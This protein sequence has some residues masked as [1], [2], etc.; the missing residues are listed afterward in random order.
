M[1]GYRERKLCDGSTDPSRED[2]YG[3][4]LGLKFDSKTCNLYIADACLGLFMVGPS[5]GVATQ[6]A[7]STDD[8]AAPFKF[9]NALDIDEQSGVYFSD[10][11]TLYQRREWPKIV[12]TGDRTGRLL[13]YDPRSEKVEVLVEGLAF[14]NGVALSQD[15]SFLGWQSQVQARFTRCG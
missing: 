13:K 8:D 1:F 7:I 11:S 9:L 5:G 4:P 6:L 10:S 15:G 12:I 2:A 3:R 14:P